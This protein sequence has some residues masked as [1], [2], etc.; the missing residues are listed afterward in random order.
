[1]IFAAP[2]VLA[3][4][5]ALPLLWWLLRATPPAPRAQD[6]PAIRLLAGL[7]PAEETPARTPWWLLALR[8]TAAGL[9]IVG[10]AGPVLTSGRVAVS[11]GGAALL[12]IDDGWSSG[13]DFA[14]RM[15]ASEAVLG[16]LERAGRPVALLTTAP[17]PDGYPPRATAAMPAAELRP[18]LAA[19]QPKPWP[20]DRRRAASAVTGAPSRLAMPA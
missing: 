9:V 20:T 15:T 14:A 18:V 13:P 10:L 4:L 19:L 2:W 3:A 17:G 11:G 1:M 12:V 7:K 6:F 8:M 16:R 5:V